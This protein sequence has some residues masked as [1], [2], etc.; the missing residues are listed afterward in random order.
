LGEVASAAGIPVIASGGVA[1]IDDLLVLRDVHGIEGVVVGRALYSGE[2][3]LSKAL[4]A[5]A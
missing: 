5:V 2:V 1:S 4:K 3:D